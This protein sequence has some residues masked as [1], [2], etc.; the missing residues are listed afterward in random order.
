MGDISASIETLEHRLMRSWIRGDVRELKKLVDRGC[1]VQFA[2]QKRVILDRLSW[3]EAVESDFLCHGYQM[4]DVY[5][6]RHGPI[7]VLNARFELDM[8]LRG[9]PWKGSFWVS[10]VWKK[11]RLKRSYLLIER[12]ISRPEAEPEVASKIRSLQLWR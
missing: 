9:K 7:A 1:I 8:E 10:D 4:G 2:A 5:V 3:L 12:S 11:S 6:R